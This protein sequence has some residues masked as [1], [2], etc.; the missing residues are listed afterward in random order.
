MEN[1]ALDDQQF[2]DFCRLLEYSKLP[3]TIPKRSYFSNVCLPDLNIDFIYLK[4]VPDYFYKTVF[5][6]LS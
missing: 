4:F 1:K 5:P 6:Y 3:N 2:S